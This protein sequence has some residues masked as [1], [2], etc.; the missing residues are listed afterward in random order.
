MVNCEEEI[1]PADVG[2][3]DGWDVEKAFDEDES[4]LRCLN[5]D[6]YELNDVNEAQEGNA[7]EWKDVDGTVSISIDGSRRRQRRLIRTELEE[8]KENIKQILGTEEPALKDFVDYFYGETSPLFSL[9]RRKLKWSHKFF[10]EFMEVK[11]A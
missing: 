2:G 9:F 4:L 1:L 3:G 8:I 11:A 5:L 6:E 7:L 10:L